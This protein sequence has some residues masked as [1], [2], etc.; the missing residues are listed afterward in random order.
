VFSTL[1]TN[2]APSTPTRLLDM[3][4]EPYLLTSCL[5]AV[6]AQRLVRTL[7]RECA[8]PAAVPTASALVVPEAALAWAQEGLVPAWQRAR[9]CES[10]RETGFSGRTAIFEILPMNATLEGLIHA[11]SDA[12]RL[13]VAALETGWRPLRW[14]GLRAAAMGLTTPDEVLRVAARW[15]VET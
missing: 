8:V 1:H 10:C 5:E 3:G 9:G 4:I 7:C 11:R 14:R 2:D 12:A 6:L 13:R 15:E